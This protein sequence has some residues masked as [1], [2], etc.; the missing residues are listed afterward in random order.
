MGPSDDP[1]GIPV[2]MAAVSDVLGPNL[3]NAVGELK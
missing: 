1:C 3:T 2:L